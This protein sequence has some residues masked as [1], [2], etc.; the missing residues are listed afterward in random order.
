MR[1]MLKHSLPSAQSLALSFVLAHLSRV[2]SLSEINGMTA[3]KLAQAWA[4]TSQSVRRR[5]A[6]CVQIVAKEMYRWR[7]NSYSARG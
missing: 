4:P 6:C 5:A 1:D 2:A 3:G 7:R